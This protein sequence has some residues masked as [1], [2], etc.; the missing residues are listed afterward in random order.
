MTHV[1]S[2]SKLRSVVMSSM[3]PCPGNWVAIGGSFA[4]N[5]AGLPTHLVQELNGGTVAHIRITEMKSPSFKDVL[6]YLAL[7]FLIIVLFVCL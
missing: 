2:E 3:H 4:N 6:C 5:M 7:F 1:A